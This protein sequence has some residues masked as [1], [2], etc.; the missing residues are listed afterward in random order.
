MDDQS[1]QSNL[2]PYHKGYDDK[3]NGSDRATEVS[4]DRIHFY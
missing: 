3:K 4:P 1:V 2:M